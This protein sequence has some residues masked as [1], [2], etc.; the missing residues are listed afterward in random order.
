[1][2]FRT[3]P[4]FQSLAGLA[5]IE[6]R[7]G[8]GRVLL[9]AG[10]K[11][12]ACL[13]VL[14]L[15][16]EIVTRGK[17]LGT[18]IKECRGHR[19]VNIEPEHHDESKDLSHTLPPRSG[20][21]TMYTLSSYRLID[22]KTIYFTHQEHNRAEPRLYLFYVFYCFTRSILLLVQFQHS[23]ILTVSVL[24][25]SPICILCEP[26]DLSFLG[27]DKRFR[28]VTKAFLKRLGVSNGFPVFYLNTEA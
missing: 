11:G 9:E 20:E 17:F 1:M 14:V 6:V 3:S 27:L 10:F 24:H 15:F 23:F 19:R 28:N 12:R 7:H 5:K 4:G 21:E 22:G 18:L 25:R 16:Q 8:I 13:L 2:H 26:W